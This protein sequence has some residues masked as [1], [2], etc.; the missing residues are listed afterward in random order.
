MD[1]QTTVPTS[2]LCKGKI[3]SYMIAVANNMQFYEARSYA[4]NALQGSRA[5][6]NSI[7]N[8]ISEY[9]EEYT[10]LPFDVSQLTKFTNSFSDWVNIPDL[11]KYD[12]DFSNG[13]TQAFDSFY[14]RHRAKRFRCF[15]GEYFYH[16][17]TWQ[18]NNVNWKFITDDMPLITGDAVIVSFPF[19]DTGNFWNLKN[20]LETC[21]SL[22]IPVLIDMCYY[23]LTNGK[24]IDLTYNC[25]DTIAFSLSKTFPVANYRI[26]V[27]YTR[28]GLV[29]GQKLHHKINYNNTL[30]AFLGNKLL[31][32]FSPTYM[33]DTYKNQQI[34]AC[35]YFNLRPS[36]SVI[37][38]IG[39]SKWDDY[40]RS[41]LLATYQLN[42][43][44]TM[45]AN[46]ICLIPIFEHWHLF[47]KFKNAY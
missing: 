45:F 17:K 15:V 5:I 7:I 43:D 28:P 23:P 22:N 24:S 18:S 40:S 19:C 27:R 2:K 47:E 39:D 31:N 35:N 46:R 9:I 25:I 38:S 36:D 30:S 21:E 12:V 10:R 42:Y 44:A 20:I 6:K 41:T 34:E 26:G 1:L 14:F 13:T 16:I 37:F 4:N 8:D 32:T 29:D 3:F 11:I 33:Q